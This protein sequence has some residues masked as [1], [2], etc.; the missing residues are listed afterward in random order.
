MTSDF[1]LLCPCRGR[2]PVADADLKTLLQLRIEKRRDIDGF[3]DVFW[4][5]SVRLGGL[6][7]YESGPCLRRDMTGCRQPV[8][9][10][11]DGVLGDAVVAG[12]IP[13]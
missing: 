8:I 3:R 10:F 9:R 2:A 13:D 4:P 5:R 1:R 12:R 6:A 11:D 7:D